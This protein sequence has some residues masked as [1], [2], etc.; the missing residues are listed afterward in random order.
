[1]VSDARPNNFPK[2][3]CHTAPAPFH[4][5]N[6]TFEVVH[7]SETK[8]RDPKSGRPLLTAAY[9]LFAA[10]NSQP[11]V[12]ARVLTVVRGTFAE[13]ASCIS[14][15]R[16]FGPSRNGDIFHTEAGA[17]TANQLH[18]LTPGKPDGQGLRFCI[19]CS[20]YPDCRE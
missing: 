17:A 14:A 6:S 4:V 12:V 8:E 20:A 18:L 19:S 3:T 9:R 5:S 10:T 13:W 15:R 11:F 1:L 2:V 16:G 7:H